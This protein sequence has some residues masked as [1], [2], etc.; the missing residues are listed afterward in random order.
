MRSARGRRSVWR[1]ARRAAEEESD[2]DGVGKTQRQ[3][4]EAKGE[5]RERKKG[6]RDR[7]DSAVKTHR[8][9]SC[10]YQLQ[11]QQ[12]RQQ[13]RQELLNTYNSNDSKPEH[14]LVKLEDC[15]GKGE[16]LAA[17]GNADA[18]N[19]EY[20]VVDFAS[21]LPKVSCSSPPST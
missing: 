21:W 17:V 2:G 1:A 7:P 8:T 11:Q 19:I 16:L 13:H 14:I 20:D 9:S 3:A 15:L 18:M 6:E 5:I 12:Q 10:T 4:G